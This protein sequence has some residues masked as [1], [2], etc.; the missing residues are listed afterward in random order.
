MAFAFWIKLQVAIAA[1]HCWGLK[2]LSFVRG[3]AVVGTALL[4]LLSSTP[5]LAQSQVA[6]G[7][8]LY[9]TSNG[10]GPGIPA[11]V[12]CHFNSA[13]PTLTQGEGAGSFHPEAANFPWLK[14]ASNF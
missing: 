1:V 9:G 11:C 7:Q 4:A 8:T 6:A 3:I 12:S 13:P 2:S 10:L 5:V 14:K